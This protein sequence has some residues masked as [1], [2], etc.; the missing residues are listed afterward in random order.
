MF[1]SSW[2]GRNEVLDVAVLC[3]ETE[4]IGRGEQGYSL[5]VAID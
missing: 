1:P 3:A 5:V 2:S 4:F